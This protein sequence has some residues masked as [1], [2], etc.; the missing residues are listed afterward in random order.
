MTMKK[1]FNKSLVTNLVAV[2]II[3]TGYLC[4]LQPDLMKSIG[5][6]ALSG[7][8]T[9][10]L[11]V[12]ML[13]EKV[14]LLYG[15]G[16][17]PN[18]FDEFKS[19]I[20]ELMMEQFFT[21]ENVEQFIEKEERQGSKVLNIEPFLHAVDYDKVYDSLVSSIM[22]SSFGAMLQMMGGEEALAPL[23]EPFTRKMQTT[24][25][26]MVES[27]RFKDALRHGLDAHKIGEDIIDKIE[28]VID[29]RLNELTPQMVKEIVQTIIREHLGWLV[30][31]GGVFGGLLGG[32]FNFA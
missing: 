18:R 27:E 10:W 15:S 2:L 20:K 16:V 12:H 4:P 28:T 32:V 29:K 21:V 23:K 7:A 1:C 17:I 31:W 11:A 26:D 22:E 24:L 25:T 9:N 8:I 5:F 6:F 19:S 30:V 13:F 3:A 14:P